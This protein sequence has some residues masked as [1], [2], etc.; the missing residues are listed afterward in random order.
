MIF[1]FFDGPLVRQ[2]A[3]VILVNLNLFACGLGLAW[4]SPVLVKL[5]DEDDLVLHRP[6]TEDEGSWIVSIGSLV[7]AFSNFIPAL[8]LDRIGRK[9]CIIMGVVPKIAGALFLGSATDVWMLLLGRALN[10]VSDAFVFTV[11]PMYAS[12]VASNAVRGSLGTILQ[13]MCSFGIVIMLSVGPFVSYS[14]VSILFTVTVVVCAV[15]LIFLPDSPY[16]LYSKGRSEEALRVLTFFRGSESAANLELK[17]YALETKTDDVYKLQLF[18]NRMF[19]KTMVIVAIFL[20][21][22]QFIGFNAVTFYLQTVLES[23]Q[24]SIRPE[25]A[26]VIIGCI[27]LAASFVTTLITDKFGRKPILSVTLIGQM[28]GMVGLGS[29]FYVTMGAT[30]VT[31]FMNFLPLISLILIVFCFSAGPGSLNW[32]LS[33]ELFDN[34]GR[35]FGVSICTTISMVSLFLTTRYFAPLMVA[36]GPAAT[37]WAFAVNCLLLCL[38][39]VLMIPETKGRSFAEIQEAMGAKRKTDEE[40]SVK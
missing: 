17:E 40:S 37:Y 7:G 32:A 6:V 8:L 24:T 20:I 28:L 36:I 30:S 39:I 29:F 1:N 2:Y 25:I 9:Y 26:S 22:V 13:I 16:S 12:E 15:P 31:G 14:T 23:T 34:A 10:G 35:A 27:Q 3:V 33:A 19:L 11:V 38:F 21:G 5:R 18:M 4:P